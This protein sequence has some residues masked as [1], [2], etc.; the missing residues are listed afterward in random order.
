MGLSPAAIDEELLDLMKGAGFNEV[1]IGA[2]S[3]CDEI[4]ESLAK[5]FKRS[6]VINT[7]NLLKK[8]KIPVTWFIMLGALC[9]NQENQCLKL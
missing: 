7:A 8:K 5:N 9:R 3:A 6:D 1:D 2:E 4:L